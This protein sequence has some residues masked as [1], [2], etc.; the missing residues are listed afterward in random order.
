L[1]IKQ[2]QESNA[3]ILAQITK[4]IDEIELVKAA[5]SELRR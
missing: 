3:A 5:M 4:I 1:E 2:C